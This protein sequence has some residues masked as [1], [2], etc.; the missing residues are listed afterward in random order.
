MRIAVTGSTGLIGTALVD[1]AKAGGHDV[2]RLVRRPPAGPD[3]VRWDPTTGAVDLDGLAGVEGAVHLAGAGVG[4]HRWTATYKQEIRDSRVLGTR[5][6]VAALGRLDPPPSVLV[7]GSAIGFYGSR[8]DELLTEESGQGTGFLS[9]VVR[10]WEAEARAAEGFGIRVA[11]ARTGLVMAPSGGAFGRLLPLIRLG[12]GGPL[13]SGR[14]WSSWITLADEVAALEHLLATDTLAGPV[15]LTAP[16]PR[17]NIDVTRA[18][19]RA[20]HRPTVLP[21]P[22]FALKIALGEF[23]DDV[24]ASARVL[25]H[26]LLKSGFTFRHDTVDA[27]AVWVTSR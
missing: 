27:A 15:N 26:R 5:T 20:V 16:Q 14:Q 8:G 1:H 6:L 3:E 25:P 12:L 21:A 7:S 22:G 10:D 24:L 18:L 19:G 2:V 23:A 11:L 4:D 9:D 13:G 17:R